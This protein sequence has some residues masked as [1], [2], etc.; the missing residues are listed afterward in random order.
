MIIYKDLH[1]TLNWSSHLGTN[2][3]NAFWK[4]ATSSSL[5]VVRKNWL[6]D[7]GKGVMI[8]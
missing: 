4:A 3:T 1:S 5:L 2:M 6:D 7:M 8:L